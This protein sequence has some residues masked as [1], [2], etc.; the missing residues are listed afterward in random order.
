MR[1]SVPATIIL[2]SIPA[3]SSC[4]C[5]VLL[6][7]NI[8]QT[9]W[10][11]FLLAFIAIS[12]HASSTVSWAVRPGRPNACAKSNGPSMIASM[13]GTLTISSTSCKAS[14]DFQEKPD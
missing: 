1:R 3:M 5:G 2:A 10:M 11:L 8:V 9:T 4:S 14:T 7:P 12:L 13:P 6:E